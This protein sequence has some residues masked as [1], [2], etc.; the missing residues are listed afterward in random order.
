MPD[1]DSGNIDRSE[2]DTCICP[3]IDAYTRAQAIDDGILADVS[4]TACEAVSEIPVAVTRVVRNRRVVL[5]QPETAMPDLTAAVQDRQRQDRQ[6]LVPG[7][8]RDRL[9]S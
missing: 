3:V 2:P 9:A 6:R 7:E 5:P 8:I 1:R 4:E